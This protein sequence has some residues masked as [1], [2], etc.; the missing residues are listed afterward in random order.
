MS[1]LRRTALAEMVPCITCGEPTEDTGPGLTV[2]CPT[3]IAQIKEAVA[4]ESQP[5]RTSEYG[6][7]ERRGR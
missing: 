2:M 1:L 3:C 5:Y 6:G 7:G 4:R